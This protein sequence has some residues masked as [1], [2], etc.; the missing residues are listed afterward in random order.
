VSL[1]TGI[2]ELLSWVQAQAAQ[3]QVVGATAELESRQLVR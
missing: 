2:P 3:D 1:A